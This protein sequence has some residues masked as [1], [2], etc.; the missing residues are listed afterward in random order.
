MFWP[1][2]LSILLE[3]VLGEC[4]YK[5]E[6]SSPSQIWF[7][8]NCLDVFCIHKVDILFIR[9]FESGLF[10]VQRMFSKKH[11]FIDSIRNFLCCLT[12]KVDNAVLGSKSYKNPLVW[13]NIPADTIGF[14]NFSL[15]LSCCNTSLVKFS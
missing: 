9:P 7:W 12:H 13:F 14:I 3:V 10:T 5:V 2:I 1:S 6:F 8:E 11:Y 4:D 15:S